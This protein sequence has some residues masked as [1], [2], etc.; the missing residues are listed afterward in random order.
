MSISSVERAKATPLL[1]SE[2]FASVGGILLT[3]ALDPVMVARTFQSFETLFSNEDTLPRY[4]L[5]SRLGYTPPGIEGLQGRDVR[6]HRKLFDF[7]PVLGP[8]F[9]FTDLFSEGT[10][11]GHEMLSHLDVA[12]STQHV[13][14]ANGRHALRVA[15]Y[16]D[17]SDPGEELFPPHRDFGLMT[18]FI[19]NGSTSLEVRVSC[20]WHPVVL[21]YGSVFIGAGT[22]LA[23]HGRV[24]PLWHRVMGGEYKRRSAV[25]FLEYND[26]Y[27]LPSGELQREFS[28]RLLTSVRGDL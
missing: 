3:D 8:R 13:S 25:V 10:R 24:R 21:P 18:L 2:A 28:H 26:D 7:H 11:L 27:L 20:V 23:L 16:S 5:A 15:E 12:H 19:G 17:E 6:Y 22:P 9:P 4:D 14:V 1:V